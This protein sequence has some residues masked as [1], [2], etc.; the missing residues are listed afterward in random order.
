M[1]ENDSRLLGNVNSSP[2]AGHS[3]Y[4]NNE[5]ICGEKQNEHSNNTLCHINTNSETGELETSAILNLDSGSKGTN[6][7]SESKDMELNSNQTTVSEEHC[8]S[9]NE[10]QFKKCS[11]EYDELVLCCHL[12]TKKECTDCDMNAEPSLDVTDKNDFIVK[13]YGCKNVEKVPLYQTKS[14][15]QDKN[16]VLEVPKTRRP[17]YNPHWLVPN[18]DDFQLVADSVEGVRQLLTK[19]SVDD[20]SVLFKRF[21][22]KVRGS[23]M[24]IKLLPSSCCSLQH[25]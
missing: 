3:S 23:Y 4:K 8:A 10:S 7:K 6:C 17:L 9:S 16:S 18:P 5:N 21:D 12:K 1:N 14:V 2:H 24:I 11:S 19:Y 22:K 15:D 13:D 20:D 25:A